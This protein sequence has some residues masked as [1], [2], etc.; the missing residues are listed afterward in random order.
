MNRA[1]PSPAG[2]LLACFLV[3]GAS[4][5][6]LRAA[7]SF[8]QESPLTL[9][10]AVE[11]A[12]AQNPLLEASRA[13]EEVAGEARREAESARLP[14]LRFSE[15]F[16]HG[17]NPVF[18]FGSLLEQGRFGLQNFAIDSLNNPG[19][20]SNFRTSLD[21]Q[22]PLLNRRAI[23]TS[24]GQAKSGERVARAQTE[25]IT[26][27]LR[28]QVI[29]A[30]FSILLA[31]ERQAVATRAVETARAEERRIGDLVEQGVLVASDLLAAQAQ[32]AEFEQQA[33]ESDS[34]AATARAALNTVLGLPV[35]QPAEPAGGLPERTFPETPLSEWLAEAPGRRPEVLL[36]QAETER[37]RQLLRA[38]R[39]QWQ[40]DL[41]LFAQY[42]AS[43][44]DLS[45]GSADFTVGARLTFDLVDFGRDSRISRALSAVRAAEAME[46]QQEQAVALEVSQ[47][48]QHWRAV[49]EKRGVTE[50]AAEQAA[51]ALRIVRD[52]HE[53]GLTTIT[54]LL[55]AQTAQ[56]QAQL[57]Q[58][59]ARYQQT[60]GYARVLLASGRLTDVTPFLP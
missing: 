5:P 50:A 40:P 58:L 15:A 11:L 46:R 57:N 36:R 30:F 37:A 52:R 25:M 12:L 7:S 49:R 18:A 38:A 48:Y 28:Y 29:E 23:S 19:S 4:L 2:P 60:L 35:T 34:G 43:S 6:G 45:S 47:A 10:R 53:V 22:L 26:Q 39:G 3:V 17:N 24:I 54:E 55:R 41:N 31:Q 16:S 59:E 13:G 8:F 1:K 21:L 9:A 33:I 32:R 27:Q 20:L 44:R 56:L 42:G 14:A 51:E